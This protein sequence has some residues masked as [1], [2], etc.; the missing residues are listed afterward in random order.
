VLDVVVEQVEDNGG[1][2]N[3]PAGVVI[4]NP[5]PRFVA[6][7][8][9]VVASLVVSVSSSSAT[10]PS[11]GEVAT[12]LG[13][14]GE[15]P[16]AGVSDE[17]VRTVAEAHGMSIEESRF[18]LFEG[19]RAIMDFVQKHQDD[20]RFGG[21][22]VEQDGGLRIQIRTTTAEPTLASELEASL[23]RPVERFVGGRSATQ[24]A[25]DM[26]AVSE[27]FTA[28]GVRF[29]FSVTSEFTAGVVLVTTPAEHVG[30]VRALQ[31]PASVIVRADN[32]VEFETP[33]SF[34]GIHMDPSCVVAIPL[35][36]AGGTHALMTAA[37]CLDTG[38]SAY[39]FNLNTATAEVCADVDRQIHV[40][41]ATQI[42]EGFY[43]F[44]SN[45]TTTWAVA[46]G[47]YPGQNY[48]RAG[49]TT[50]SIGTIQEISIG[51]AASSPGDCPSRNVRGFV[52][53]LGAGARTVG[54]DSGGSLMLAYG[55]QWYFAGLSSTA[56]PTGSAGRAAWRSIPSGWTACT[57]QFNC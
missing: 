10:D 40:T 7:G 46:G 43:D 51:S 16:L 32:S 44:N 18:I 33:T 27:A 49:R 14:R 42:W 50:E 47:W 45:W 25:H 38:K 17:H 24:I 52:L 20:P 8:G 29:P 54:G 23:E 41:P 12:D 5:F 15:T 13:P 56:G 6:V 22:N 4:L 35:Q 34:A 55:G 1:P 9:L 2:A 28:G 19:S 21:V 31:L 30:E 26:D 3:V 39:G 57:A 36:N 37:H 11:L 53:N 48:F